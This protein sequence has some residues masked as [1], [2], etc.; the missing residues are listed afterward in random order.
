MSEWKLRREGSIYLQESLF[1]AITALDAAAPPEFALLVTL[2]F[3][4]LYFFADV[5]WLSWPSCSRVI[6]LG[7]LLFLKY[8]SVPLDVL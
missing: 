8:E 7:I 4:L 6:S 5:G 2:S 3:S 1:V